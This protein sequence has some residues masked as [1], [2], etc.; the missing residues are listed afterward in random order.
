[1]TLRWSDTAPATQGNSG[2]TNKAPLPL[3]LCCLAIQKFSDLL[4]KWLWPF[5]VILCCCVLSVRVVVNHDVCGPSKTS[6]TIT[7]R[8]ESSTP[9]PQATA[10]SHYSHLVE[11][12]HFSLA[13]NYWLFFKFIFV[14]VKTASCDFQQKITSSNILRLLYSNKNLIKY[15]YAVTVNKVNSTFY[16]LSFFN[17]NPFLQINKFCRWN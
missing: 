1:M 4:Q 5:C 16:F 11:Y 2:P 14:A 9:V 6:R 3:S 13:Y 15:V 17:V 7:S 12:T 8:V 10:A